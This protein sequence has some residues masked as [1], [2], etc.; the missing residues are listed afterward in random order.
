MKL[1]ILAILALPLI[2][3]VRLRDKGEDSNNDQAPVERQQFNSNPDQIQV[4]FEND[5]SPNSYKVRFNFD[6]GL[7]GHLLKVTKKS[8]KAL[9]P[10]M[11]WDLASFTDYLDVQV[12]AGE[13]YI[14]EFILQS[15][16][17]KNLGQV[18]FTV[19]KDLVI[20][21]SWTPPANVTEYH[22][23]QYNRIFLYDNSVLTTNGVNLKIQAK[24]LISYNAT[25]QAFPR[26]QRA[27]LDQ[28]GRSGGHIEINVAKAVGNLNFYLNG[29]DGGNGSQGA[30]PDDKLKGR[31]GNPGLPGQ[32]DSGHFVQSKYSRDYF[33]HSCIRN[34]TYGEQGKQGERGYSGLPGKNG[35]SSA[36]LDLIISD[37]REFK[38]YIEKAPGDKGFGGQG[39]QGG[40]PGDQGD[41]GSLKRNNEVIDN[42]LHVYSDCSTIEGLVVKVGSI[43]DRGFPGSDGLPGTAQ[44]VC[45][46]KGES[47]QDCY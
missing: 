6:P 45:I 2:S 40:A 20:E 4:K 8:A 36:S 28:H 15:D 46:K 22:L 27:A 13:K 16:E 32:W 47:P 26:H 35:G 19:P 31:K 12:V 9:N 33:Q 17:P 38:E 42:H 34:P 1:L 30:D 23:K 7:K 29:E 18:E 43:G 3:C 37:H 41:P 5:D 39:G 14:Y 24:E 21:K 44:R 10:D 25:I 11:L